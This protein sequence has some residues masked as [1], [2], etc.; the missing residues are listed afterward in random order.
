MISRL[1]HLIFDNALLKITSLIIA[2]LMWYGVA[3]EPV[4]EISVR[5]PIEFSEPPKTLDFA[6]DVAPQAQVWLRGPAR[7]LR[8]LQ[9]E[10]VHV[11]ID[12]SGAT[13]GEHTYD[14][15]AEQ[16]HVPQNV[17]VLQITPSRLRLDFDTPETRQVAVKPRIVGTLPPGYGIELIT[18]IPSTVNLTGPSR[19]VDAIDSA[20]TDPVDITGIAGQSTVDTRAY[21]P[22]PLVHIS[23]SNAVQV[24]I[25]SAKSISKAGAH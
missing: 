4:A 11:V 14:I 10:S 22:D 5:V 20:L 7:V 13:T 16:V 23:G 9:A 24:T 2:I 1:R 3:H 6:S 25:V 18:V 19:H 8:D 12:L 17:D 21:L 15:T